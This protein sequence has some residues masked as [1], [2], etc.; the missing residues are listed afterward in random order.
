MT[1][2]IGSYKIVADVGEGA[3]PVPAGSATAAFKGTK[4][5]SVD[6]WIIRKSPPPLKT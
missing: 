5:F 2:H 3:A 1:A 4:G 6:G